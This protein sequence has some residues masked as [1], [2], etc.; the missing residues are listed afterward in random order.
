MNFWRAMPLFKK[1]VLL[2]SFF[3]KREASLGQQ[4]IPFSLIKASASANEERLLRG[5]Y[6][7]EKCHAR[8]TN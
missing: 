2:P 1:A 5:M 4:G 7:H 6:A 3:N 8:I